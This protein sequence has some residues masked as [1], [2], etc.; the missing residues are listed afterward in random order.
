MLGFLVAAA[1]YAEF[2]RSYERLELVESLRA[3]L[4][5]R[6]LVTF[7]TALSIVRNARHH[8]HGLREWRRYVKHYAALGRPL[9]AMVLHDGLLKFVAAS[10]ALLVGKTGRHPADSALDFLRSSAFSANLTR[11]QSEDALVE[12]LTT[13]ALDE[14]DRLQNDVDYLQRVGSAWQQR[15]AAELKAR[16]ITTYLCCAVYDEDVADADLLLTWLDNVLSD[17]AQTS[18]PTLA[19]AALK[20]MAILAKVD[21]SL[22]SNLA[23]TLPRVIVQSDFDQET[24]DVAADGLASVLSLLPQDAII[25]TLYSLGNVISAG[26]VTDRGVALSPQPNG[27][28][29]SSR[30]TVYDNQQVMGSSISLAP[31][32]IEEPHHVHS[33]VVQTVVSVARNCK[34]EKVTALA[35]SMLIQKIGR[36]SRVVDAKI[37]EDSAHLGIHSGQGEFRLLLK[38]YSKLCHDALLKGD[39]ITLDAVSLQAFV[40]QYILTP[41]GAQCTAHHVSGDQDHCSRVRDLP[42]PSP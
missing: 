13:L 41:P 26:P 12:G 27:A 19:S 15:Q 20:A 3:A 31:S 22:A 36:A 30:N 29:K 9:G 1:E 39:G 37:I 11:T 35:L 18:N 5:E 24:A 40:L 4:S 7:E 17:P 38:L 25:T 16:I 14:M 6:F 21:T 2:W 34:D 32:D 10:A 8:Q 23:H 28:G 42:Y 33:T